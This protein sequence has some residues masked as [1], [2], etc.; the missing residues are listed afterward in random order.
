M[1]KVSNGLHSLTIYG[2]SIP[3]IDYFRISSYTDYRGKYLRSVMIKSNRK[4]LVIDLTKSEELLFKELK[5]NTRNEIRKA[6]NLGLLISEINNKQTFIDFYNEFASSKGLPS[7][8]IRHLTK[9]PNLQI[10]AVSYNGDILTMHANV[11]DEEEKIVRLLYSA[12]I[13]LNSNVNRNIIGISNRFLHFSEFITFKNKH[14][15]QYDFGGINENPNDVQ[16][17]NITK[18]KKGFG[19]D[20]R[21]VIF[22][23]SIPHWLIKKIIFQFRWIKQRLCKCLNTN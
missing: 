12:S 11:F 13:R 17:Y 16:Q 4:T 7:I 18:F 6:S 19:G 5:S 3:K 2:N 15:I 10:F 20:S 9:Y 21:D 14:Y 8:N 1:I 22:L 23:Q